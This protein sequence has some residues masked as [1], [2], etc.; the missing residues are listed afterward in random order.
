MFRPARAVRAT[1]GG[2]ALF[3]EADD[4]RRRYLQGRRAGEDPVAAHPTP[5]DLPTRAGDGRE[6][7]RP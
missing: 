4:V 7:D 3:R 6:Y 5:V 2:F 1:V